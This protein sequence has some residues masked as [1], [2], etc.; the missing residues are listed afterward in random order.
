MGILSYDRSELNKQ[1]FLKLSKHQPCKIKIELAQYFCWE[2]CF[3]DFN[4]SVCSSKRFLISEL[5]ENLYG[6]YHM[7]YWF[8]IGWG[9]M[10]SVPITTD[11]VSSNFDQG[12]VRWLDVFWQNFYF[13]SANQKLFCPMRVIF[14]GCLILNEKTMLLSTSINRILLQI[15]RWNVPVVSENIRMWKLNRLIDDRCKMMPK[16]I[17]T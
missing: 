16:L 2:Y 10:Q 15:F 5:S 3:Y 6:Y 8:L 4:Q 17:K 13:I 1:Y 12:E 9:A 11:G 7:R 14:I